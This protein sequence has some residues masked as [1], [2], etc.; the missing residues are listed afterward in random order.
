M[1]L[2][3]HPFAEEMSK[4][5]RMALQQAFPVTKHISTEGASCNLLNLF[6][7]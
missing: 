4:S 7:I 1:L 3:L 2:L 5:R 6:V